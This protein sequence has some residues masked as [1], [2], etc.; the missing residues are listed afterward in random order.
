MT[1]CNYPQTTDSAVEKEKQERQRRIGVCALVSTHICVCWRECAAGS[2][3][4]H[5][6]GASE[7]AGSFIT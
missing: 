7:A 5:P 2:D 4:A 1:G 6:R 3:S